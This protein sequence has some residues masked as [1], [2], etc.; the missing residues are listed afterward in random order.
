MTPQPPAASA[1]PAEWMHADDRAAVTAAIARLTAAAHPHDYFGTTIGPRKT[2]GIIPRRQTYR[3]AG[4]G[5]RLGVVAVD[6][7]GGLYAVGQIVR[8]TRQ[9]LPGHQA[10]SARE[11]RALKEQLV[12]VGF[13]DGA[14]VLLDATLITGEAPTAPGPTVVRDGRVLVRWMPTAPDSAL[15]PLPTY[16]AE[17]TTLALTPADPD[18]AQAAGHETETP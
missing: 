18:R 13:P 3:R 10:E 11:R 16:L 9:V 1:D 7:A 4:V 12:D 14:T 8:A 6:T 2:L 5:W 17:R 15:M